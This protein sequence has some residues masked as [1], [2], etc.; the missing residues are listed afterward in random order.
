MH[1]RS[2]RTRLKCEMCLKHSPALSSKDVNASVSK[3]VSFTPHKSNCVSKNSGVSPDT[4]EVKLAR[5]LE[6][7]QQ[8]QSDLQRFVAFISSLISNFLICAGEREHDVHI[9]VAANSCLL[10]SSFKVQS[11]FF[12]CC[13]CC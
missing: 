9:S 1:P 8:E 5:S 4:V 2:I 6:S 11:L 13:C 10:L 12:C 7:R 3:H